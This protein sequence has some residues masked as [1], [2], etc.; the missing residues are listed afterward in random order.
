MQEKIVII[1]DG[2]NAMS[3]FNNNMTYIKTQITKWL[4]KFCS[5]VS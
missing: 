2:I 4:D 3:M 5:I 1:E